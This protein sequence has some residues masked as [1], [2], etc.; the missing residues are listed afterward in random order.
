MT[1]MVFSIDSTEID[2][3]VSALIQEN[4]DLKND[5]EQISRQWIGQVMSQPSKTNKNQPR[6]F[7]YS[8][9]KILKV[10]QWRQKNMLL[11]SDLKRR[12]EV[13]GDPNLGGQFAIEFSTGC[14]YGYGTDADGSPN[15][16]VREE[17]LGWDNV[18][19]KKRKAYSGLLLQSVINAMPPEIHSLNFILLLDGFNPIN[20]VRYPR[21]GPNFLQTF[22]KCCPDRLKRA[23]MVTGTTGRVFYNVAK[24]IAPKN[25][26]DK[27]TVFNDRQAAGEF[28]IKSGILTAPEAV[29][30]TASE[31]NACSSDISILLPTFLG[32][33]SKHEEEVT[34]SLPLMLSRLSDEMN[35][36]SN[37]EI[38]TTVN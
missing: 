22:M 5:I 13:D 7:E 36:K 25:L 9:E 16:W 33:N 35:S 27:I 17:L 30:T 26:V 23:V 21:L 34:K 6:S 18:D 29:T 10:I 1:K 19:L 14:F 28:L 4:P 15:L 32:G 11:D 8:K 24:T 3:L 37:S 20:V 2:R 31:Q 12:I 38:S